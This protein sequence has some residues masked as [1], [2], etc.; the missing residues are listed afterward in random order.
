MPKATAASRGR[1]NS[2][3]FGVMLAIVVATST[4]QGFDTAGGSY[5]LETLPGYGFASPVSCSGQDFPVVRRWLCCHA[6]ADDLMKQLRTPRDHV[7][8]D[9]PP[10]FDRR[11][12]E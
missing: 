2:S 1:N 3:D 8:P 4:V 9:L 7:V 6:Y 11:R 5:R 12:R 10:S